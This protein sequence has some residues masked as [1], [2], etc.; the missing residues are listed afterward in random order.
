MLEQNL[1]SVHRASETFFSYV[2]IKWLIEKK[3]L[4]IRTPLIGNP[5]YGPEYTMDNLFIIQKGQSSL[6]WTMQW[7]LL[8]T[9]NQ[10]VGKW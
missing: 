1:W 5:G 10:W 7:G 3:F 8:L 6:E 2:V 9:R 4:E